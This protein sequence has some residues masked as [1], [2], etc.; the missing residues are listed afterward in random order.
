MLQYIEAKYSIISKQ[1]TALDK[2]KCC[3]R[4]NQKC[5]I[6]YKHNSALYT[7]KM[8]HYIYTQNAA[9]YTSKMWHYIQTKCCIMYKQ[10]AALYT[11]NHPPCIVIQDGC[12][13]I[14]QDLMK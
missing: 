3:I 5:C 8:R 6:M 1:N 9:L 11:S 14:T 10:N 2:A 12:R 7:S 4:Y 13:D